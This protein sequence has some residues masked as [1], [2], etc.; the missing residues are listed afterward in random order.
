M[1][2]SRENLTA[3]FTLA[4]ETTQDRWDTL[5]ELE[6]MGEKHT[7][8]RTRLQQRLFDLKTIEHFFSTNEHS[9]FLGFEGWG[10]SA[11]GIKPEYQKD[12]TAGLS[13]IDGFHWK[14]INGN[15]H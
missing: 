2:A 5:K 10:T 4:R 7:P 11:D 8:E 1:V 13:Q 15:H 6:S 9:Q 12:Y 3:P 14:D